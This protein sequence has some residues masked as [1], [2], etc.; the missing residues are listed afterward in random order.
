MIMSAVRSNDQ[1]RIGFLDS[2]RRINV[3]LTRAQHGLIIIGNRQ[4]LKSDDVWRDIIQHFIEKDCYCN[5]F[6]EA[7]EMIKRNSK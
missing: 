1:Q 3:A 7:L 5:N 4:T 2:Y 6:E